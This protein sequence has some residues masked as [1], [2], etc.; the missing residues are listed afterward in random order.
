M[1]QAVRFRV[2]D[3]SRRVTQP[4]RDSPGSA[5]ADGVYIEVFMAIAARPRD[6]LR[7]GEPWFRTG[8]Y[9]DARQFLDEILSGR[10]RPYDGPELGLRQ[11]AWALDMDVAD[12]RAFSKEM[13]AS[14][15]ASEGT[16]SA[17][18]ATPR[19]SPDQHSSFVTQTGCA[20]LARSYPAG[21][22]LQQPSVT[23]VHP[24][25]AGCAQGSPPGPRHT[26]SPPTVATTLRLL[27]FCCQAG[28][29][30][31][32]HALPGEPRG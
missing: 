10:R 32:Q 2:V 16:R 23:S 30:A 28:A 29:V 20:L 3:D 19:D 24:Y 11:A 27:L 14:R 25:A 7:P 26:G 12:Y 4:W 6:W 17:R 15:S 13:A 22:S 5:L 9:M 18:R 21:P 8:G 1:A 31:S